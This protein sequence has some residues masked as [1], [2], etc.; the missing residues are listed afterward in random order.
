LIGFSFLSFGTANWY[1]KVFGWQPETLR[2]KAGCYISIFGGAQLV[3]PTSLAV[4][5]SLSSL[6]GYWPISLEIGTAL[7]RLEASSV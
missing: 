7:R 4:G 6:E 3:A 5:A 2:L 1:L